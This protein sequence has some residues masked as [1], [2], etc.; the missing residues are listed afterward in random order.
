MNSLGLLQLQ[1]GLFGKLSSDG[2]LMGMMHAVYDQ[3]P[4][5]AHFPYAIIGDG[6]F[7][8]LETDNMCGARC[9]ISIRI[10]SQKPGRKE[11][12]RIMDRIYGALHHGTISLA[13]SDV[14]DV[15][16]ERAQTQLLAD[17]KTIEGEITL[18]CLIAEG[19]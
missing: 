13:E 14:V 12:L 16:V 9:S 1:Q 18:A 11:V 10:Y 6:T 7:E 5:R 15:R 17:Q 2:V 3:V 8:P 19:V 4:E